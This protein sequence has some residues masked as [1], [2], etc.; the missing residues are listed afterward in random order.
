M[1]QRKQLSLSLDIIENFK[2]AKSTM[3]IVGYAKLTS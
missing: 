1:L 2:Q 3:Y